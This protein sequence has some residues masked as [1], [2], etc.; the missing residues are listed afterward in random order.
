MSIVQKI[1]LALSLFCLLTHATVLACNSSKVPKISYCDATNG[2]YVLVNG[3]FS[4]YYCTRRAVMNMQKF[5]GC[6][7]WRGGVAS[8][9]VKGKVTCH[10]GSISELCTK[11][12]PQEKATVF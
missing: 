3:D 10:D 1:G 4:A 5:E 12:G 8:I 7:M 2:L 11:Q 9:D 6:C